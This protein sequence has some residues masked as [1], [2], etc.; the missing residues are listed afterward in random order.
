MVDY[1]KEKFR[2]FF[3]EKD[4]NKL[5]LYHEQ[6]L[7]CMYNKVNNDLYDIIYSPVS[8]VDTDYFKVL[9]AIENQAKLGKDHILFKN[10]QKIHGKSLS[11]NIVVPYLDITNSILT[12]LII[13]SHPEDCEK[14]AN[15]HIKKMPNFE[16][17]LH[18][19]LISTTNVQHWKQQ[20]M[21][22]VEA[23]SPME[24]NSVLSVSHE[25][26]KKCKNLLWDISKQGKRKVNMSDFFLNETLAQLQLAMF[27]LPEEF[28][29]KTNKKI[30]D[31]FG[32]KG[33][34]YARQY[35]LDLIEE[36]KKSK[37][38]LSL[39][40]QDIENT[41]DTQE[42]GNALIFSFAGHDTTGH[43]LTWLLFELSKNQTWQRKLQREVDHFWDIQGDEKI[44]TKDFR[45]LPFMT[46]CIMETLRLH[47]AVP[48]GTFRELM[49][50]EEIHGKKGM[51]RIPK[52]TYV[53]IFNYSRHL[54]PDLWGEDAEDF[55]PDRE[56]Q[57]NELWNDE[58]HAFYN[59]SS[60]RFSP[61]TYGPRDCIGKNFSQMEMR[62]MLLEIFKNFHFILDDKQN[63]EIFNNHEI[64]KATMAPMDVYDPIN[65][66]NKG[67]RPFNTGMYVRIIPRNQVVRI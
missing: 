43:T 4:Q 41:T 28:Q 50:D 36:I 59:P 17:L 54:N 63:R 33:R 21:E 7:A 32:G 67:L 55:N 62:V 14:I 1:L 56:F 20:R 57:G 34:G 52:G 46:R 29:K 3:T 64:N 45:R 38:P 24:L 48:N 47:T 35:A 25:R 40:F 6:M 27:G 44:T 10:F 26:A 18:D 11:E 51:V 58:V 13:L 31:A 8:S 39:S 19:S 16:L 15:K 42:Y 49:E 66:D 12:D 60:K 65:H 37:G 23:F 53:Q 30:R 2:D 9:V 22:F 5:S 61:F